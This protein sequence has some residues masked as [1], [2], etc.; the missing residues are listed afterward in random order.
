MRTL[1]NTKKYKKLIKFIK[2][3]KQDKKL[4]KWLVNDINHYSALIEIYHNQNKELGKKLLLE[5]INNLKNQK[6]NDY[7]AVSSRIFTSFGN[8]FPKEKITESLIIE[9]IEI[10]ERLSD[11]P[12]L[13]RSYG[14]LTRMYVDKEPTSTKAYK[15]CDKWL[16]LNK[17]LNDIFGIIMSKNYLAKIYFSL[18]RSNKSDMSKLNMSKNL[19]AEN[20]KSIENNIDEGSK[21]QIYT[22]YADLMEIA[23]YEKDEKSYK[24]LSEQLFNLIKNFGKIE[25]KFFKDIFIKAFDSKFTKKFISKN[26]IKEILG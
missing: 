6:N 12:G 5:C 25:N 10:K 24:T 7:L 21:I 9:S 19:Y 11:K 14:S 3:L 17:E 23:K 1:Y 13:A 20:I 15:S 22:S 4:P 8:N 2:D 16:S 18:Y 26:K